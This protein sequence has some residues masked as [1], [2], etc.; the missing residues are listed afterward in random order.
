MTDAIANVSEST[1]PIKAYPSNTQYLG[2]EVLEAFLLRKW[3]AMTSRL[4]FKTSDALNP[5]GLMTYWAGYYFEDDAGYLNDL[6]NIAKNL[7]VPPGVHSIR[8]TIDCRNCGPLSYQPVTFDWLNPTSLVQAIGSLQSRIDQAGLINRSLAPM[9]LVQGVSIFVTI[10]LDLSLIQPDSLFRD[11][12]HEI[13][14]ELGRLLMAYL[15]PHSIQQF[16]YPPLWSFGIIPIDSYVTALQQGVRT[17]QD[18]QTLERG[19]GSLAESLD[20]VDRLLFFTHYSK[21][22]RPIVFTFEPILVE[23]SS[24][25]VQKFNFGR[26][27]QDLSQWAGDSLTLL[28]ALQVKARAEFNRSSLTIPA[29]WSVGLGEITLKTL[30]S[31]SLVDFSTRDMSPMMVQYLS[32]RLEDSSY[33]DFQSQNASAL[34]GDPSRI[35]Q[36]FESARFPSALLMSL[37]QAR[38]TLNAR[39][40]GFAPPQPAAGSTASSSSSQRSSPTTNPPSAPQPAGPARTGSNILGVTRQ[41]AGKGA[42]YH[43]EA[44]ESAGENLLHKNDTYSIPVSRRQKEEREMFAKFGSFLKGVSTPQ[45]TPADH[46]ARLAVE[47]SHRYEQEQASKLCKRVFTNPAANR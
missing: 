17:T 34:L 25:R 20:F 39:T 47:A 5:S 4:F 29:G 30:S 8:G 16:V 1:M 41:I 44:V 32:L 23:E 14:K 27:F 10:D 24:G 2:H 6:V 22:K 45:L 13:E 18:L 40:M 19:R 15:N 42:G 38:Q 21:T 26:S 11:Y 3:M 33:H 35:I 12:H 9:A 31:G 7:K 46:E 28:Q 43:A 36:N 37:K